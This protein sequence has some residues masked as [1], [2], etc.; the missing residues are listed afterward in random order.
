MPRTKT[1]SIMVIMKFH[2]L[3]GIQTPIATMKIKKATITP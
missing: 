2:Y 3:T 1:F